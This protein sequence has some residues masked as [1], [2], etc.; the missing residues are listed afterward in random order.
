MSR[1]ILNQEMN[2]A[3][4]FDTTE[5]LSRT[6]IVELMTHAKDCVMTV[7]FHKKVDDAYVREVLSN[8]KGMTK[9][10]LAKEITHG[11]ECTM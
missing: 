1:D 9:K 8:A 4:L 7:K 2:S 10:E 3:Q 5:K 11:K 6:N